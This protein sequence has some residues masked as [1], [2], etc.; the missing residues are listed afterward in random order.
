MHIGPITPPL[1]IRLLAIDDSAVAY[2]RDSPRE[3]VYDTLRGNLERLGSRGC[4]EV[5]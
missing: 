2:W 4:Q 1:P 5:R 3:T